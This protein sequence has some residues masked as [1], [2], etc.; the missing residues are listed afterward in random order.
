MTDGYVITPKTKELL[1]RH[2]QAT[3]GKVSKLSM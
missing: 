2:L 3:G 1:Q